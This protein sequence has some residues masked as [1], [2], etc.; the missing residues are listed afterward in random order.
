MNRIFGG[1]GIAALALLAALAPQKAEI[2]NA[3]PNAAEES[4]AAWKPKAGSQ[5]QARVKVSWGYGCGG[6]CAFNYRG[7]S[8]VAVAFGKKHSVSVKDAGEQTQMMSFPDGGRDVTRKWAFQWKGQWTSG[9]GVITLALKSK[10]LKCKTEEWEGG[11]KEKGAC[12]LPPSELKLLCTEEKVEAVKAGKDDPAKKT[13][14]QQRALVCR[15]EEDMLSYHGT[16]F[17]WTMGLDAVLY[18]W[19]AGE[20]Q[21]ETTY[22]LDPFPAD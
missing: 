5:L 16:E 4:G 12:P 21:P 15:A 9:Q 7:E 17:P 1:F 19:M 13:A 18:T 14:S 6:H 20:P 8:R 3:Q 11:K 2:P 22:S 10:S